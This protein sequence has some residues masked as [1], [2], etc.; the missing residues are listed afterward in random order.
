MHR[1]GRP[2]RALYTLTYRVHVDARAQRTIDA[3]L[4]RPMLNT[5]HIHVQGARSTLLVCNGYTAQAI[6]NMYTALTTH[7]KHCASIRTHTSAREVH[8][9]D[10]AFQMPYMHTH[11]LTRTGT[12]LGLQLPTAVHAKINAHTSKDAPLGLLMPNA[13]PYAHPRKIR[14]TSSIIN[15]YRTLHPGE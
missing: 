6:H 4:R 8:H 15:V 9:S 1:P 2:C 12:R 5:V 10:R 3:S 13:V 7:A 11:I 14:L